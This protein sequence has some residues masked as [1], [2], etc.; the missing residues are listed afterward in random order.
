MSENYK[1]ADK[2]EL[3]SSYYQKPE[4]CIHVSIIHRHAVLE[5][6]GVESSEEEPDVITKQFSSSEPKAHKI[7]S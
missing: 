4:V 6:D 1:C 2:A 5:F 7:S 3:Q